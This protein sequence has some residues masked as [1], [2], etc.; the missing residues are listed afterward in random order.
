MRVTRDPKT[1]QAIGVDNLFPAGEGKGVEFEVLFHSRHIKP[2]FHSLGAGFAGGIVSAAV[3][4]LAI[5][6]SIKNK[7]LGDTSNESSS[8]GNKFSVGF[9]Y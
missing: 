7:F 4:G 6:E 8:D 9:D 2:H 3:D 5:A 1:L